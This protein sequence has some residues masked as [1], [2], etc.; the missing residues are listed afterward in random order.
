MIKTYEDEHGCRYEV[1]S[2]HTKA[3]AFK[4]FYCKAGE[5]LCH[6]C[7][8]FKWRDNVKDA[9]A[10]LDAYAAAHGWKDV[11]DEEGASE[12]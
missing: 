7:R 5:S 3:N 2:D 11:S 8:K 4:T 9:E 10:D 6:A 12:C 1:G